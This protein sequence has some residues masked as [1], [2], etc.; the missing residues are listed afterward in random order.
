MVFKLKL[1]LFCLLVLGIIACRE[2]PVTP[3]A[4]PTPTPTAQPTGSTIFLPITSGD[5]P[6][7]VPDLVPTETAVPLPSASPTPTHPE[8]SGPTLNRDQIGVQVYLHRVDVPELVAQLEALGVGWVKAQVSWKLFQP[9]PDQFSEERFADLDALVAR[10]NASGI[11]V[12]LSVAK[13]PEWSRPTAEL[14]GPP[15]EYALYRDFMQHLAS[16]Y[17]GQVAAYELWNEPNLQRE[18]NGVPL[19]AAALVKLVRFG[20][21]GVRA[22]D[23]TALV[24]SGAPAVTGIN[25]GVTAVDDRVYFRGMLAAGVAEVVDGFGVHPYGWANPPNATFANPDVTVPSHNDHPSF[26]FQDTLDDYAALLAEFGVTGKLLWP[27]EFGWGSFESFSQ[28]PPAGAQFMNNV[29]EWQQA[30]YTQQAYAL[31]HNIPSV[32]PMILWNLNF[33]PWLGDAFSESGYSLLRPDG[34]PRPAFFALAA[35]PKQ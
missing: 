7:A 24:I 25:D 23:P 19:E 14:D 28:L 6:A 16:K 21:D 13:A 18:W 34:S 5:E 29:T 17:A 20:A 10:A 35:L 32:G 3:T 22:G 11:Q 12:M 31:A 8:Y 26:F 9:Y 15:A 33:A 27:T 4:V 1:T 2:V 30:E